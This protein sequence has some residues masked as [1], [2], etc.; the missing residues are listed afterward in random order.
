MLATW[1]HISTQEALMSATM[2]PG[3]NLPDWL[4]ELRDQ[5][6]GM[7]TP[8]AGQTEPPASAP[9][10]QDEGGSEPTEPVD[11]GEQPTQVVRHVDEFEAL[12]ERASAEPII[13]EPPPRTLPVISQLSPFQRFVLALMLFLNVSVLGCLF[14]MVAGKIALVR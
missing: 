2:P 1:Q 7:S 6:L 8:S 13:D 5:Q 11:E 9:A 10:F 3:D 14:L 4:K 12:R